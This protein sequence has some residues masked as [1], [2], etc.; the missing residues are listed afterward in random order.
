MPS[1]I[2]VWADILMNEPTFRKQLSAPALLSEARRCFE[3]IP[4]NVGKTIPLADHLMSGLALFGFKYPSLL[5]FDKDRSSETIQANLRTLYGIERA[6][7]DTYFRERLDDLDPRQFR[8]IYKCFFSRLQRSKGLEKFSYL[9]GHYLLSLNGTDHFSSPTVHCEHCG[10]KHHRNGTI[11]YYH[12]M[13]GAVL[14]H[15][16]IKEVIPLAPE[17]ILKQD[18][19]S[20]NDCERNAAKRLLKDLRRE[21]PHLKLIVVEDALASNAPHI[22]LLQDLDLRFILGAKPAEHKFLFDWVENCADT[23]EYEFT[24]EQGYHHRFRYL[25]GAPLNEANSELKVN[26]LEYWKTSPEGEVSHF[27]WVTDIPID[28]TNLMKLMRGG[29][30]RWKIENETF[31]TLKNQGYYFE[32]NFGHGYKHLTTVLMHLMMLVFL[33]D[34]IQQ[35]CCHVFQAALATAQRKSYLWR[36]LRS[37]F[38]LCRIASWEALYHPSSVH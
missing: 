36:K 37:R 23:A 33:I 20:K 6:P 18:G 5:Q 29:R 27:S 3:K 34:Q 8:R 22:R 2:K 10:E 1:I 32:H 13:L 21:H 31:N 11:T 38:D 30:A 28:E 14:I 15:P 19:Q 35:L 7:S 12:Q 9:D 4:D 17:P 26:F 25:N 16:D 24:D